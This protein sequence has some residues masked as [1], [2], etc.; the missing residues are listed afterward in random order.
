[1]LV[2]LMPEME[3]DQAFVDFINMFVRDVAN[4]STDDPYFPQFRAFDWF[5]MHSW[6]RGLVPNSEGKDQES[7]SE[8]VNLHYGAMLWGRMIGNEKLE[9][10]S[11]TMLTVAS[12]ALQ[13]YFLNLRDNRNH[14]ASFSRH[15]VTGIFFQN[16]VELSTWFGK[17][18]R[19]IHG[20]QM[21]P[22]TA[23]V[24]LSRTPTFAFEEWYDILKDITIDY[25]DPWWSILLTGNLALHSPDEAWDYLI[26]MPPL[27]NQEGGAF[28]DGLTKA[29]ALYWT[30]IQPAG[31]ERPRGRDWFW[32]SDPCHVPMPQLGTQFE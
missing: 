1:M 17:D 4:P 6:S 18:L 22:L 24:M 29:W 14:P 16:K 32:Q 28:D 31:G 21:L 5:D 15:H 30:S 11:A 25:T 9:K 20:I 10:L 19:Y 23:G 13:E 3:D 2:E 8:E 12:V 26:Q 7:T 27:S